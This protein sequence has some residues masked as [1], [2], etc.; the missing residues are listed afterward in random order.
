VRGDIRRCD[1]VRQRND[2]ARAT[3]FQKPAMPPLR[4]QSPENLYPAQHVDTRRR[5][6]RQNYATKDGVIITASITDGDFKNRRPTSLT[7][8]RV[9]VTEDQRERRPIVQSVCG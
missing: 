2:Q 8:T 1:T 6:A 3:R 4:G 7:P 9:L 5:Q